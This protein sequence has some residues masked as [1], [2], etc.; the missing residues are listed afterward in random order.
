MPATQ[1][2]SPA[3]TLKALDTE[4]SGGDLRKIG[5][6]LDESFEFIGV[7][8][9]PLGK[10]QTIGLWSTIRAAFPDFNHNLAVT[11]ESGSI[12]YATVEV[13]GTH[14]GTLRVP[15]G[16]TIAA[17]SRKVRL[18]LERIAVTVRE[19]KVTSWE[20]EHVPG[21]GLAGVLGQ[22]G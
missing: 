5:D 1:T 3:A 22:I 10:Q 12:V 16:P 13:T 6:Y 4:V 18:P 8:P 17:S 9:Q 14:T 21:G 19:G 2:I 15:N 7:G 20:I 11:R